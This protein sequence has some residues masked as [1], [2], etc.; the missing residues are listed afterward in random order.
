MKTVSFALVGQNQKQQQKLAELA[1]R[2]LLEQ[3]P[4]DAKTL[5][6]A[7]KYL[8]PK[9]LKLTAI[10][11]GGGAALLAALI[12]F[13]RGRIYQAAVARELKKQLAPLNTKL[14][15]LETQNEE[16]RQQNEEL[17]KQLK[18]AGD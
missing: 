15:R 2:R 18:T 5:R 10:A 14:D 17:Q 16:L 9:Y 4:V 8:D 1:E 6:R 11:V 3:L 13:S 7:A 12:A